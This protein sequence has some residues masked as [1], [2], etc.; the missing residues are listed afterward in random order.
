M[1][2]SKSFLTDSFLT[3]G[4]NQIPVTG[5]SPNDSNALRAG[6]FIKFVNHDKVY[7]VALSVG[8]NS[9]GNAIMNIYP[10]LFSDV[11]KA[12]GVVEATFTLRMTKDNL[13][14]GLDATKGRIP[15]LI[16]AI[17]A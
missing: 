12:T 16:S 14:L 10:R 13:S 7:K 9:N 3:A 4:E 2:S 5:L 11:S 1:G 17:E 15:V 8:S 6:D